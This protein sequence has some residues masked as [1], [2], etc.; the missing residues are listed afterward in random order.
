MNRYQLVAVCGLKISA[1]TQ[2]FD[3]NKEWCHGK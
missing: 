1:V 2:F 3:A